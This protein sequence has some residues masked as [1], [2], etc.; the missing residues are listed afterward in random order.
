MSLTVFLA[1][2]FA[3]DHIGGAELTSEALIRSS[4]KPDKIAK[5]KCLELNKDIVDQY[6]SAHWVVLNFA[7]LSQALKLYLI[8]N[9]EYSMI[10]YDY[11]FCNYRSLELCWMQ[12]SKECECSNHKENKINLAF[13]GYAK[14]IWFMSNIQKNIFL[15][16]VH[17]IKEEKTETLNSVFSSGDLRFIDSIKNNEKDDTYLIVKT[18]SWVK[19]FD[20][21]VK[22]AT[23]NNLKHEI[24]TNLPYHELLIKLS[25]SRG[26][27]FLPDGADTCPRLVMEAQ[28]LGCEVITNNNVQH[29]DEHW[30]NNALSCRKHMNTR[31]SAF[32]DYYE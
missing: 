31:T 14:K 29:K 9:V 20:N 1:D 3:E 30:A 8:K 2:A 15:E 13:Y 24:V 16:K 32:W 21:C 4:P 23:T 10:E 22:Y 12:T 28:M 26:L 25:T 6:K 7:T 17:T 27:I 5:V 11:K 19:G 18:Q